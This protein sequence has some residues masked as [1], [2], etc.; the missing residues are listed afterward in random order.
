MVH[1]H[2]ILQFIQLMFN[3]FLINTRNDTAQ[4]HRVSFEITDD[5]SYGVTS[6]QLA[7]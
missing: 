2:Y 3:M 1:L 4:K 7:Y 5:Y 6:G